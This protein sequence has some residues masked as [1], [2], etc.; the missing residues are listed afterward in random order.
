MY[1]NDAT[2]HNDA[3]YRLGDICFFTQGDHSTDNAKISDN[4]LTFP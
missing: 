2:Y 4:S 1:D 3:T